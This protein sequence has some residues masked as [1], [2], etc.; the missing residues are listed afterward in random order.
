[1]TC[2]SSHRRSSWYDGEVP[3]MMIPGRI[4]EALIPRDF[5]ESGYTSVNNEASPS[6]YSINDITP[7][8]P[9]IRIS[10]GIVLST[11]YWSSPF[12]QTM[13]ARRSGTIFPPHPSGVL[14]TECL[15]CLSMRCSTTADG[16]LLSDEFAS[17]SEKKGVAHLYAPGPV[18]IMSR[19][20]NENGPQ[21]IDDAISDIVHRPLYAI[22]LGDTYIYSH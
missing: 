9:P 7:L 22:K 21:A 19:P 2:R 11:A 15:H 6:I 18:P 8:P 13:K 1:M 14:V 17:G 5:E 4:F 10:V 12:T 20:T 16:G 3:D